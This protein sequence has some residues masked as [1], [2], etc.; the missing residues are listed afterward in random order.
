MKQSTLT[1]VLFSAI[2]MA[3]GARSATLAADADANSDAALE[4]I[5][6]TA[7]K[8]AEDVQKVPISIVAFTAQSLE[9][10]NLTD[11]RSLQNY[12]PNLLVEEGGQYQQ[13]FI[14]GFGSV[15]AN[16]AFDQSVSMYVDGVYGGRSLQF[17]APFFDVSQVEVLRGPQ[18]ALLGKNTAAGAINVTTANPTDVFEGGATISYNF[19]RNGEDVFAYVS[20]PIV[21]DLTG[22]IAVHEESSDGWIHNVGTGTDD[23]GKE[24]RETR[25]SLAYNPAEGI[26]ILGKFHYSSV[27]KTGADTVQTSITTDT[28]TTTKDA[29]PIFGMP[30]NFLITSRDASVNGRMA[31]GPLT[32]ESIT[33]YSAYDNNFT[34]NDTAGVP[35][36]FLER[37]D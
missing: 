36:V 18:G 5:I 17:M 15:S 24:V 12:V 6:V 22:R 37:F 14:R 9:E 31:L 26:D 30:E 35:A 20:G 21:N 7:Q 4:T 25:L 13:Y 34:L 27:D 8:R 16:G 11:I 32:L 23:P 29:P 3:V 1:R 10:H 2:L 28:I 33:G 19:N